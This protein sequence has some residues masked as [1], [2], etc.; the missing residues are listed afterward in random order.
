[1]NIAILT[2]EK[3]SI[4]L[5]LH[6]GLVG[7]IGAMIVDEIQMVGDGS[8][9]PELELLLTRVREL[10]P[11]LQIIGLSAVVSQFNG[12]DRWLNANL[13]TSNHRPVPLR[14]GVISPESGLFRYVEWIGPE[15][16]MG[17]EILA[18]VP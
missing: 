9:G 13:I 5:V 3:L 10:A 6:P 12:F 17:E 7:R 16:R 18:P 15:K 2:Y 4:L 8:R 11:N 1:F 14:E